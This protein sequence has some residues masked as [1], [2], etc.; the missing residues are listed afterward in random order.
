MHN[1]RLIDFFLQA[2]PGVLIPRE[3][4]MGAVQRE[5][6][7]LNWHRTQ[8]AIGSI[9]LQLAKHGRLINVVKLKGYM[10]V[11]P[12]HHDLKEGAQ[13]KKAHNI[14]TVTRTAK[15]NNPEATGVEVASQIL[16][17]TTNH[18][19]DIERKR[20]ELNALYTNFLRRE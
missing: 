16:G 20:I 18:I 15:A 12:E 6:T 11:R 19:N 3:E 10:V 4:I 1:Q 8:C 7:E 14:L 5:D 13:L 2:E 9:R 17:L